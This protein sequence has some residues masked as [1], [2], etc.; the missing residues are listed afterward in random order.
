MLKKILEATELLN[1]ADVSGK[2][3]VHWLRD[4][5]ANAEHKIL[6]DESGSTDFIKVTIPGHQGQ[7]SGGTAPTLGV[8]GR[9]GGI[10]CRPNRLGLVS[11][12]DGAVVAI[13]AAAFLAHMSNHGDILPGD[14]LVR[15][16][17]SPNSPIIPHEPAAFVDLPIDR[18]TLIR[19]EIDSTMNGILSIDST[20]A[21]RIAKQTGFGITGT[22]KE[23]VILRPTN[24]VLDI[25]ERTA[26][27]APFV[28]P[29][30]TQDITPPGN[31]LHH[32]NSLLQPAT[33][34]SVPVIGVALL[35]PIVTGGASTG[36]VKETELSAAGHFVVEVAKEFTAG[37]LDLY[38]H[39]EFELFVNLYGSMKQLQEQR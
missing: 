26:G 8:I 36:V 17:I 4:A 31:G 38:H 11:D 22:I 33:V 21:N 10:G 34:T 15:T 32:I 18:E 23:G 3:V 16:H 19:A 37:T 13:A 28:V 2:K 9:L 5:G 1:C 35:S 7:L 14:V 20:R 27:Q 30:F 12:G 29:I 25:Y 24:G 39:D 6:K